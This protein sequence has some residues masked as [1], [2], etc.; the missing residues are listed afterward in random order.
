MLPGPSE[1]RVLARVDH[2][3]YAAPDVEA[4]VDALEARLGVRAAA[5]G[6]HP[7]EGTRNFLMALGPAAYL[8][9]VGPDWEAPA[10]ARPRW[11]GI[12]GLKEPRLV[13]WAARETD[14]DGALARAAGA[15]VTLG[16][17]ASGSR[18]RADGR[19][20][21]WRFTDPRMVV[22]GGVVP[23]LIDWGR[24]PHPALSAP[25]GVILEE[26]RGEHPDPERVRRVLAAL[27]LALPVRR[28]PSPAL[29]ALLQTPQGAV[30]LG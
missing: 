28:G 29:I 18:E 26:L 30:E 10:P 15:G 19:L 5:G 27:D 4:A 24:T 13:A 22:E 25:R 2:L 14:L 21:S 12:D 9:I 7:S 16:P 23:F 20:L 6:R 1:R 8:E 11:L 3:V 17:V